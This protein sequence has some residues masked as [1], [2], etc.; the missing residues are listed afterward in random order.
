MFI[1]FRGVFLLLI[2]FN[3]TL[4]FAQDIT[5]SG[6]VEDARSGERLIGANIYSE[7]LQVGTSTNNYGFFSLTLPYENSKVE[8]TFSFIGYSNEKVTINYKPN[9]ILQIELNPK[10]YQTEEVKVVGDAVDNIVNST[11]MSS[12]NIPVK[13]IY[14]EKVAG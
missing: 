10:T 11:Q 3:I 7:S 12:V 4:I 1:H 14:I 2:V 8:L 9:Q 5:I 6:Y 13:Q